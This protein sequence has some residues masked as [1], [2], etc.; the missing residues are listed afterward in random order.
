MATH[1]YV[2]SE[3]SLMMMLSLTVRHDFHLKQMDLKT[4]F[5]NSTLEHKAWIMFP[6]GNEHASDDTFA[7]L[8]K[9]V[10]GLKQAT[11]D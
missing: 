9:L 1:A 5:L 4:A 7:K 11:F 2:A 8:H 10:Y 6:D 3:A